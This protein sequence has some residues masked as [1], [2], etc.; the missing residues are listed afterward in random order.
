MYRAP[1]ENDALEFTTETEEILRHWLSVFKDEPT[2]DQLV[3]DVL[4]LARQDAEK[5]KI[6]E[7]GSWY[8][9]LFQYEGIWEKLQLPVNSVEIP[10]QEPDWRDLFNDARKLAAEFGIALDETKVRTDITKTYQSF[11][12]RMSPFDALNKVEEI[13]P[14]RMRKRFEKRVPQRV[15]TISDGVI[16]PLRKTLAHTA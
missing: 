14:D 3:S 12:E 7:L 1:E 11:L 6:K 2:Y 13:F 16:L 4:M 10:G 9:Q 5:G 8:V 15:R